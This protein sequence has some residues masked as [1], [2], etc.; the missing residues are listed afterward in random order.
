MAVGAGATDAINFFESQIC[1]LL[2]WDEYQQSK[3]KMNQA[4]RRVVLGLY[5]H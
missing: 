3:K 5:K 1:D 2:G 4:A